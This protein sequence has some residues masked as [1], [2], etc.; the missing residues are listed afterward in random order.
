M[1]VCVCVCVANQRLS[2][3]F[4]FSL[5]VTDDSIWLATKIKKKNKT[6]INLTNVFF[7][8]DYLKYIFKQLKLLI[9][10]PFFF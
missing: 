5:N 3:R 10:Q 7:R 8:L 1:C 9:N 4:K 2:A 6:Q